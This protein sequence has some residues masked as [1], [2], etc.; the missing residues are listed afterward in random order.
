[1]LG[2]ALQA[3]RSFLRDAEWLDAARAKAYLWILSGVVLA[4]VVGWV[5][6]SHR[7]FDLTGKPL[8]TD[9]LSFWAASKLALAGHPADVYRP[10]VHAAA[11]SAAFGGADVGYAAFFYPPV[12]LLICL[13]LAALPYLASLGAWLVLTGLACWQVLRRWLGRSISMLPALAFPATF[14]NLG[15]GQNAFLTTALFGG[16]GLLLATRPFVAGA[17]FGALIFK[18]HLGLLIPIALLAGRQWRAIAGAITSAAALVALSLLAFGWQT[19][20]GFLAISK[21]ARAALEQELVGSAKMQSV[22]A[23]IRL[24]HGPI[25][26]A[27]ALQALV[28]LAAAVAVAAVFHRRRNDAGAA[29]ALV[30]GTLL[31]SPFLL[32][33]DLMLMAIPLA[34]LFTRGVRDGFLPWEKTGLLTAYLLPLFSR[35]I[36]TMLHVPIGPPVL[37]MLFLLVLRRVWDAAEPQRA[38]RRW[39]SAAQDAEPIGPSSS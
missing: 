32:D 18:P 15:H 2:K 19:W 38:I 10:A 21:L 35:S 27:Y 36:A 8:G 4:G 22:F 29:A 34:W 30:A 31:A 28:A 11:Q 3:T 17:C 5:A 9:F 33:Y 24:W 6:L 26:A 39:A 20:A 14:S 25:A 37:A 23:A 1:M 16:G 7:G 13:P 12:F